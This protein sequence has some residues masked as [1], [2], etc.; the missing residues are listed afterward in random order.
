MNRRAGS[1]TP[2]TTKTKRVPGLTASQQR[3]AEDQCADLG[4]RLTPARLAAYAEVRSHDRPLSAYEL[5]AKLERREQR[6]IA[7]LTVYRHLDFLIRV[8]LVHRLESRQAYVACDH[9]EHQH[10]SQYLLCSE[11]GRAD[12]LESK[13][14]WSLLGRLTDQQGF[15]A[16]NTVVEVTGLCSDCRPQPAGT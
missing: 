4:E 8:G 11:C 5:I 3:L 13:Q 10:D 15:H 6:K 2:G 12:E 14:L 9:P 7:P 16:V 1:R